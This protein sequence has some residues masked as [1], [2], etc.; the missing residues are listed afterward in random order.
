MTIVF[1]TS[2]CIAKVITTIEASRFLLGG[3]IED[4]FLVDVDV[5][6]DQVVRAV[7]ANPVPTLL[8]SVVLILL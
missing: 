1:L 8:G 4:R 3:F 6:G 7:P 5:A 2:L